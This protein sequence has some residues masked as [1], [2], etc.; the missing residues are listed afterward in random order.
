VISFADPNYGHVGGIYQ[1]GNWIYSGQTPRGREFWHHGKRLHSRQVAAK[2]WN[3]QQGNVRRT[4]RPADC[5]IVRTAGKYRYL[6]PLDDEM[7]AR[8][9][10]FA[11]PFPKRAKLAGSRAPLDPGRS[12]SDPHAPPLQ[13]A[14]AS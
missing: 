7:R 4:P 3:I 11:K 8:V 9:R 12:N 2:G 1:A 10:G 5:H 6:M 14:A 13:T